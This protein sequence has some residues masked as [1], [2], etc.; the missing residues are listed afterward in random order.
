MNGV[1][2]NPLILSLSKDDGATLLGFDK[3]SLSGFGGVA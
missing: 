3:L 2:K 1:Y